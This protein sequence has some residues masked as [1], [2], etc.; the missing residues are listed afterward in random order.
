MAVDKIREFCEVEFN[1]QVLGAISDGQLLARVTE[2]CA[3]KVFWKWNAGMLKFLKPMDAMRRWGRGCSCHGPDTEAHSRVG[4]PCD[5]KGRRL[6]EAKAYLETQFQALLTVA[7]IMTLDHTEG[8]ES[9]LQ[10]V[11]FVLRKGLGVAMPKSDWV[12]RLPYL[13]ANI[14]DQ[15]T[16]QLALD[17]W[18]SVSPDI[19]HRKTQQVFGL[20]PQAI[21]SIAD[22][23][24]APPPS[25]IGICPNQN[26]EGMSV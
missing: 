20:H 6:H 18:Y 22:G 2:I 5:K 1:P 19:H 26:E 25:S 4:V 9:V 23:D 16:A 24:L 15:Q 21:H 10:D 8:D 11:T 7:D 17:Q 14:L 13:F 12:G 3:D